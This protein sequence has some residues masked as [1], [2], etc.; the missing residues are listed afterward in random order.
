[1]GYRA[2]FMMNVMRPPQRPALTQYL[3]TIV[4][5]ICLMNNYEWDEDDQ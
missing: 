3:L 2:T 1:M 4:M 5:M